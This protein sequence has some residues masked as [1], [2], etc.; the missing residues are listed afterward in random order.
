[1]FYNI[2]HIFFKNWD[3]VSLVPVQE[4][5]STIYVLCELTNQV[6]TNVTNAG[7]TT[8]SIISGNTV[9]NMKMF[10]S[11]SDSDHLMIYIIN[12]VNKID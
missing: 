9:V 1:M 2:L 11:L 8:L 6:I 5:T 12:H 4:I 7:Y 3:V 10:M